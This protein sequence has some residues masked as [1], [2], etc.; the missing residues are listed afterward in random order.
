MALALIPADTLHVPGTW[1][2]PS[3]PPLPLV[4]V[5]C[6]RRTQLTI[7]HGKS[8]EP[9]TDPAMMAPGET[10][11][12]SEHP[13]DHIRTS[14]RANVTDYAKNTRRQESLFGGF[15]PEGWINEMKSG[16]THTYLA[17][18]HI[19]TSIVWIRDRLCVEHEA[20]E[21]AKPNPGKGSSPNSVPKINMN[22]TAIGSFYA[23]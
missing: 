4:V 15:G 11:T 13:L 10:M 16:C 12:I 1:V 23:Q 20:T 14:T 22:T 5:V 7:K 8:T 6:P 21:Y 2:P 17:L 3:N 19:W 18:D 9:T